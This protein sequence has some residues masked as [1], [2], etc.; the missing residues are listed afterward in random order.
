MQNVKDNA[1]SHVEMQRAKHLKNIKDKKSVK[2]KK[3]VKGGK[4]LQKNELHVIECQEIMVRD[5]RDEQI[6]FSC[7]E[8]NGD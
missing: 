2:S 5:L 3:S 6:E 8:S 1:Q 4:N 7:S